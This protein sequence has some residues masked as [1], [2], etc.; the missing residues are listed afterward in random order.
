[1]SSDLANFLSHRYTSWTVAVVISL[2]VAMYSYERISDP[3]PGM[4]RTREEA[5]VKTARE[6]L[7]SYVSP[8]IAL[9]LVDPLAPERRV[10][11]VYIYPAVDGWEVSGHY[12]RNERDR[13][14]PFLMRLS[15][16]SELMSL[17]VKDADERLLG[18]SA[19]DPRLSV[20][21]RRPL[22]A[23]PVAGRNAPRR[24]PARRRRV[25]GA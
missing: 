12:R 14:H 15:D 24:S 19:R 3:E 11:K 6:I 25:G 16:N 20:V 23:G 22:A 13:W 9:E 8:G 4:Q 1:M 18:M 7:Q 21:P 17:A 2:M 10:G 5:V